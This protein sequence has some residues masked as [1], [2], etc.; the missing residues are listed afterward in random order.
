[1]AKKASFL[2]IGHFKAFSFD[3]RSLACI[4]Q[5]KAQ[6]LVKIFKTKSLIFTLTDDTTLMKPSLCLY[7]GVNE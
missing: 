5:I 1:M 2:E 6:D 3:E 7:F 4:V